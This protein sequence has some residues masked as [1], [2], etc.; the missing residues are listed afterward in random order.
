MVLI[1]SKYFVHNLQEE[2]LEI[3]LDLPVRMMDKKLNVLAGKI[4]LYFAENSQVSFSV[5][6]C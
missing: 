2:L 6:L 1:A 4:L 5:N 3:L